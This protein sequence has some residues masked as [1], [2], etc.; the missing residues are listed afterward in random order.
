MLRGLTSPSPGPNG[1]SAACALA[2]GVLLVILTVV[3]AGVVLDLAI[4]LARVGKAQWEA[5]NM[6]LA[7]ARQLSVNGDQADALRAANNWLARNNRDTSHIQ[8]CTFADWRPVGRPDGVIDTVTATSEAS[9]TTL[10]LDY[11]GLPKLFTVQR[12]ATAQVV[13]ATG[14]PICPLGIIADPPSADAG[15]YYGLTPGRV[16]AFDLSDASRVNGTLLPLDLAGSGV[17]GYQAALA[18]GCRKE[19]TGVWSVGDVVGSLTADGNVAATT[20][21]GLDDYFNFET[22]DGVADYLGPQWCDVTFAYDGGPGAGAVT[23]FDPYVQ[24]PRPECVRG[25]GGGAGRLVVL[26][27]VTRPGED[28]GSVRILGLASMYLASWDRGRADGSRIY[29]VFFDNA[30]IDADSADLTGAG[31]S[32]LAPLRVALFNR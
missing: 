13:R 28:G 1:P 31:D 3:F 21:Q 25:S 10:F 2:K 19:E 30:R 4:F 15:G 9:H 27:V 24:T 23:G 29:G 6:A 5:E 7:A 16:Y 14:A 20:L 32:P 17:T 8:C 11:F 26:P 22:G 12:S 18:A